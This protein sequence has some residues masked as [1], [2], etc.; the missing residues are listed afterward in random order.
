MATLFI[1]AGLPGT[2]KTTLSRLLARKL[3]VTHLRIDTV[4]QALRDLCNLSVGGEGYRLTY[5]IASDILNLGMDVVVDSCN[6]IELTRREWEQV[7]EDCEAEYVN[8]ELVCSDNSEHRRRV[9]DR[10]SDIPGLS[11]P[12]WADVD[13]REYHAWTTERIVIDTSSSPIDECF[14]ELWM[15]LKL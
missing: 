5:R 15:K 6:P 11:L 7:A 10:T 2:G 9:E 8:I 3:Q 14:R 1:F 12:S 4:E 13:S